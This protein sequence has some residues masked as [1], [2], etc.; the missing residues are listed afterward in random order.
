MDVRHLWKETI[1]HIESHYHREVLLCL[2][3]RFIVMLYSF[4]NI[5]T[6]NDGQIGSATCNLFL[7]QWQWWAGG[8][9][10]P[11]A[12][13][14]ELST[15]GPCPPDVGYRQSK[16]LL[17]NPMAEDLIGIQETQLKSVSVYPNPVKNKFY[18]ANLSTSGVDYRKMDV[19]VRVFKEGTIS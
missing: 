10:M 17:G 16:F 11:V 19:G 18:R 12:Q 5:R 3:V 15:T 14:F 8:Y 9:P 1:L 7:E 13:T 2:T 4:Y 6:W